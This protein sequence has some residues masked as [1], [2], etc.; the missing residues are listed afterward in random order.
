MRCAIARFSSPFSFLLSPPSLSPLSPRGSQIDR[1]RLSCEGKQWSE[2]VGGCTTTETAARLDEG[3]R[4]MRV[5]VWSA[6]KMERPVR[7]LNGCEDLE[8]RNGRQRVSQDAK[9]CR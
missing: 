2:T 1:T 4:S 7:R 5:L 9:Q 8:G 3:Y 6:G